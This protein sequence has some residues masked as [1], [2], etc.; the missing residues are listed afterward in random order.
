M[1][2]WTS[3]PVAVPAGSVLAEDPQPRPGRRQ[4]GEDLGAGERVAP[5]GQGF[6]DGARVEQDGVVPGLGVAERK[7]LPL[8]RLL[9]DE[10]QGVVAAGR[11]DA[12]DAGP[13][14]VHVDRQGRGR[15]RRGQP[16]LALRRGF[17]AKAQAAVVRRD[18]QLQVAGGRQLRQVLVEEGVV[19]VVAGRPAP[20]AF[21]Q[22]VRQ[23]ILG[24]H[25]GACQ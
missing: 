17:E 13:H 10:V 7:D 6:G 15:G 12:G 5:I 2:P 18:K 21:Q 1:N 23:D 16:P 14:Q 11:E 19:P 20:D 8:R 25:G 3:S 24:G 9:Q 22:G 4:A